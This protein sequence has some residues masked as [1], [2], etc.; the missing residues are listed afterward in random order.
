[1]DQYI[2][3]QDKV[4]ELVRRNTQSRATEITEKEGQQRLD[5]TL[6]G[7]RALRDRIAAAPASTELVK[8]LLAVT[9]L[10]DALRTAQRLE[11]DLVINTDEC[12]AATLQRTAHRA[13]S[14]KS[15]R[16]G[17]NSRILS[18][19]RN[20]RRCA[21]SSPASISGPSCRSRS[22][23]WASTMPLRRHFACRRAKDGSCSMPRSAT[24]R[25]RSWNAM[26]A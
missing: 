9:R 8:T 20:A 7:L 11:K 16:A 5:Q 18:P 14:A 10:S 3:L 26:H 1:M 24:A 22:P 25:C 2:A 23:L 19:P 4:R 13:H 15:S 21:I 17:R 12:H 6:D